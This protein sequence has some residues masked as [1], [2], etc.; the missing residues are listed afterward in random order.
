MHLQLF[1]SFDEYKGLHG[2]R[3]TVSVSA[4][5]FTLTIEAS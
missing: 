2:W 5:A 4:W 1:Y 3:E